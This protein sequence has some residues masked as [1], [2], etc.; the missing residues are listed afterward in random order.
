MAIGKAPTLR[1]GATLLSLQPM[2]FCC[3]AL[4]IVISCLGSRPAI[5][6][7]EG[8]VPAAG[9]AAEGRDTAEMTTSPAQAAELGATPEGGTPEGVPPETAQ[10]APQAAAPFDT[11]AAADPTSGLVQAPSLQASPGGEQWAPPAAAA[12]GHGVEVLQGAGTQQTAYQAPRDMQV[13]WDLTVLRD[14]LAAR[15]GTPAGSAQQPAGS[16][17]GPFQAA[18][19]Q[20]GACGNMSKCQSSRMPTATSSMLL[21]GSRAC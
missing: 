20:V 11:T 18:S 4:T 10:G 12:V 21:T 3:T 9:A 17:H 5:G 8:S 15:A 13:T 14:R 16:L 2:L 6:P 1:L 7:F 19:L